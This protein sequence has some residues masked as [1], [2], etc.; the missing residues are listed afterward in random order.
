M[1]RELK[2]EL[3][4]LRSQAGGTSTNPASGEELRRIQEQVAETER[5]IR[6]TAA[7]WEDRVKASQLVM[8]V[9]VK[10]GRCIL[11]YSSLN[12]FL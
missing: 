8:E 6:E 11:F 2:E 7:S 4:F 10:R 12:D 5:L 1:I 9:R 3:E